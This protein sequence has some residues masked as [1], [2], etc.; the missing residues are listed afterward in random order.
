M[1]DDTDDKTPQEE[2]ERRAY[3][4]FCDRGCQDGFDV[5]DWLA[6][7]REVLAELERANPDESGATAPPDPKPRPKRGAR[8]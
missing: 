1:T 4:R 3:Q 7:E 8:R 6:A 2:I 5:D